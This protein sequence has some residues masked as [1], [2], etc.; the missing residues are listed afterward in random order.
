MRLG[1]WESKEAEEKGGNWEHTYP[2]IPFHV[3]KAHC[4]VVGTPAERTVG[5]WF[6][7]VNVEV[8][9]GGCCWAGEVYGCPYWERW[10][11]DIKYFCLN[12][13][14]PGSRA[15]AVKD[16]LAT[17]LLASVGDLVLAVLLLLELAR[18]YV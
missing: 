8:W 1:I 15:G 7:G 17:S 6:C 12:G 2:F 5:V 18:P 4:Y 13:S 9:E 14:P 16:V 3:S 10:S 11:I